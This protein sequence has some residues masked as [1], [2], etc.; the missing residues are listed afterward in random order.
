MI[1]FDPIG[2]GE[3]PVGIRTVRYAEYEY[4]SAERSAEEAIDLAYKKLRQKEAEL[5]I[6]DVIK[7]EL[8]G[9]FEN[10]DGKEVYVLRCSAVSVMNIA[11]QVKIEV[12]T[13]PKRE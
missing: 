10:V 8:S 4:V 3:L 5:G 13:L 7:K 1:Y 9:S 12:E 11:K 2:K 6:S